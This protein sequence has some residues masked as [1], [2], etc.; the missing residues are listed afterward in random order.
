MRLLRSDLAIL[1]LGARWGDRRAIDVLRRLLAPVVIRYC[2]ARLGRVEGSYRSADELANSVCTAVF[3][4]LSACDDREYSVLRV[5][6]ALA[7]G[8]L[9]DVDCAEPTT[10]IGRVVMTLPTLDADVLTMRVA[11]GLSVEETAEMLGCSPQE[12][13]FVQHRALAEVRN[14]LKLG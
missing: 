11:V 12:I 13:R 7:E 10:F 1:V 9:A 3:D 14:R 5:I 2:R 6:R 8:K 4:E